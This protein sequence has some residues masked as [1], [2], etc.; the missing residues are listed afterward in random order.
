MVVTSGATKM[1]TGMKS[2]RLSPQAMLDIQAGKVKVNTTPQTAVPPILL[3]QGALVDLL[4][5]VATKDAISLLL[6]QE[7]SIPPTQPRSAILSLRSSMIMNNNPN[8]LDI[9]LRW[10]FTPKVRVHI[11]S[12][13]CAQAR[14]A[15]NNVHMPKALSLHLEHI[16][17]HDQSRA[18]AQ[19]LQTCI[20]VAKA[21]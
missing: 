15:N 21:L 16:H 10:H 3:P 19:V 11:H 14:G 17:I 8:I 13:V 6:A 4:S 5:T 1:N 20:S 2:L 18:I 9:L 7:D 12:P